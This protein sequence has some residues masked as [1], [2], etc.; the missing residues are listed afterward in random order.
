MLLNCN[1]H[2]TLYVSLSLSR[3]VCK[4]VCFFIWMQ[5]V[6]EHMVVS[7]RVVCLQCMQG[8]SKSKVNNSFRQSCSFILVKRTQ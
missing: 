2:Q 1:I 3:K 4:H 6:I 5:I 8:W 7:E